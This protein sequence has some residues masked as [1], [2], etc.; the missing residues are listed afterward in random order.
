MYIYIYISKWLELV[1]SFMLNVR[2]HPLN[3]FHF[4]N[5]LTTAVS[6]D[7]VKVFLLVCFIYITFFSFLEIGIF[8]RFTA[9]HMLL[10]SV[11]IQISTPSLKQLPV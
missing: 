3:N 8:H 9:A 11:S 6:P 1:Q 10:R 2:G 7:R 5:A 4:T